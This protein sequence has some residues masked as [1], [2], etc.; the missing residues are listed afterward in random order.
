MGL[1]NDLLTW[2]LIALQIC[3]AVFSLIIWR[4]YLSPIS[5]IPGPY[6]ASFTRLWHIIRIFVGDQNL[7]LIELH[8]K[9]GM[10][11][12]NVE[13]PGRSGS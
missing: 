12:S 7:R 13:F 3:L 1:L 2:P 9:H 11:L 8:D 6:L 10:S 4:R 5:D